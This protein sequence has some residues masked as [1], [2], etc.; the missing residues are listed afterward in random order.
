MV[1]KKRQKEKKIDAEA[2]GPIAD[3]KILPKLYL[4][5]EAFSQVKLPN[6]SKFHLYHI[7]F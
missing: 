3:S 5:K 7:S 2:T 1:F 6:F 4:L